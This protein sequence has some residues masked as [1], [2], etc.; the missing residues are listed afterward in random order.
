M[1]IQVN[2][3]TV[4]DNSRNLTNVSGLKT[5][6]GQSIL[7]SG[8]IDAGVGFTLSYKNPVI[9]TLNLMMQYDAD[10]DEIYAVGRGERYVWRSSDGLSWAKVNNTDNLIDGGQTI[11]SLADNGSGTYVAHVSQERFYYSTNGMSTWSYASFPGSNYSYY[12][13][14]GGTKKQLIWNGSGFVF[15]GYNSQFNGPYVAYS[16]NG[17]SWTQGSNNLDGSSQG[18][19]IAS[20]TGVNGKTFTWDS[21]RGNGHIA[22]SSNNGAS[23]SSSVPSNYDTSNQIGHVM[24]S[25]YSSTLD[26]ILLTTSGGYV[27]S[28]NG[29]G[30]SMALSLD[31]FDGNGAT[32]VIWTSTGKFRVGTAYGVFESTTGLANSWEGSGRFFSAGTNCGAVE[33]DGLVYE[34]AQDDNPVLS[35]P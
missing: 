30:S 17:T 15:A 21:Q 9:P 34:G 26:R 14:Y 24:D 4:I 29:N 20:I 25:A 16:T 18:N 31:T 5:V 13:P 2:G 11:Y 22:I 27:I 3:T 28:M 7:G 32:N 35:K 33:F 23:W 19:N 12:A 8:N 6:G 1:A 10:R